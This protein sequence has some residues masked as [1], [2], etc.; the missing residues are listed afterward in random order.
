VSTLDG[1]AV[2]VYPGKHTFF[3]RA[4]SGAEVTIE[5]V[6]SEGEKNR[7]LQ[8]VLQRA[9]AKPVSS[10]VPPSEPAS[11]SRSLVLPGVRLGVAVVGV[12]GFVTFGGMGQSQKGDLEGSCA[13]SCDDA[14]IEAV[15]RKFL[16]ADIS[17]GVG[18]L[19]LAGS[20]YTYF[21]TRGEPARVTARRSL[22]ADLNV[23]TR[24][25]NA[26]VRWSF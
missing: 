14:S 23:S 24:G 10:E 17:L 11:R 1:K 4:A 25:A 19:A 6:I 5:V 18:A 20:A 26:A 21:S 8:V 12:A 9:P 7:K 22:A 15:Q 2:A 3:F 16:L 13:P